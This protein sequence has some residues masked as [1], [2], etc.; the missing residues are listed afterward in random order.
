MTSPKQLKNSRKFNIYNIFLI[1][2]LFFFSNLQYVSAI[3]S[4]T[5]IPSEVVQGEPVL[6]QISEAKISDIKKL[7]FDN[8]RLNVFDY[9][10]TPSALVGVDLRGKSGDFPIHLEL[11]SGS[12]TDRTFTIKDRE[13]IEQVMEVPESLGGNSPENQTKVVNTL[14]DENALLAV[15]K[16]FTGALWT[17]KFIYPVSEPIITDEY[18]YSRKTGEYNLAHKGVDFKAKVGTKVVAMNK[19][20][21]R[22]AKKFQIYGNTIVIDHGYGVMSFYLHLS[23]IKVNVGELV[24]Q[25]QL[26]GL[27]GNT[28]YVIGPHLHLSVRINNVS[29]DPIKFLE[30]FN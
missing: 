20:I 29:I 9:K 21:V 14:V 26:I 2:F 12:T 17:K 18:G 25:G 8:K 11:K 13:K 24:Q 27:S 7:T 19:G 3:V 23:K 1:L 28:G 4:I 30:L 22:V 6:I 15:I 5:T 10:S 16:T